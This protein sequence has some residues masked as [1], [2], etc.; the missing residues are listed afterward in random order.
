MLGQLNDLGVQIA[1]DDFDTGYSSWSYLKRFPVDRLQVDRSFVQDIVTDSDDA[2]I[3][4]TIIALGHNLR[5]TLVA[6]GVETHSNS[7]SC[8]PTT[9]TNC[10]AASSVGRGRV[11]SS[12]A[13]SCKC[14]R[15]PKHERAWQS[16]LESPA[17][18]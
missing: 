7:T 14:R 2:T 17:I 4:R 5:L 8:A 3:V 6:E 13:N 15:R 12:C 11:T 10:R 18:P 1:L 9:A 16:L